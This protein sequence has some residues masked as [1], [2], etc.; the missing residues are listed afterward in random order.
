M[1]MEVGDYQ[2]EWRVA[3]GRV[4]GGGWGVCVGP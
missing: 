1:D 4:E 3:K 2:T